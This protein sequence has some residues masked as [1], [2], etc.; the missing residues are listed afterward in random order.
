M[1]QYLFVY[2]TLRS[3]F[4]HPLSRRLKAQ[5]KLIG[6]GSTPGALYDF[7]WYPGAK[8]DAD[9]RS[10]VLGEV[11]SLENAERL[12]AELDHY[13]RTAE[14]GNAFRRV[15]VKV[16]LD[17]GGTVDAWSY[18]MGDSTARRRPIESGDFIHCRR[19]KDQR[20]IPD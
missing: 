12:L 11:F 9:A 10:R 5:A 20:P 6:K 14:P 1:T 8:F 7:G 4:P 17:R 19:L 16:R 3:E 15:P 13:E 18:E 2:G